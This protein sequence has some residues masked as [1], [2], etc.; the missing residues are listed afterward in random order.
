MSVKGTIIGFPRMGKQRELK[1]ILESY[2]KG[3]LDDLA[4]MKQSAALRKEHLALQVDAGLDELVVNDF[5]LYDHVLD[6]AMG[7][8]AIPERYLALQ[9]N[10]ARMYFAMARGEEG[11]NHN[12]KALEMSKWFNTN[13][14]YIVP[15][16]SAQTKFSGL[17]IA[18]KIEH[19]VQ[20]AREVI[21]E[22]QASCSVRPVLLGPISFLLLAK[23]S[24][25]SDVL[26]LLP[27]LFEEYCQVLQNVAEQGV[28]TIQIDEPF[29]VFELD[30]KTKEAYKKTY[31]GFAQRVPKLSIF[32]ASYFDDLARNILL[33]SQLPV[34]TVH[35]DLCYGSMESV[36]TL[37]KA[38]KNVSL[39]IING[40]N[41]WKADLRALLSTLRSF[42]ENNKESKDFYIS[43]SC[44]L[45]H[46]PFDLSTDQNLDAEIQNWLSFAVQKL[47]E[48]ALLKKAIVQG[49]D[50]VRN[51]L[52][53]NSQALEQRRNSAR[54]HKQEVKTRV[55][56]IDENMMKRSS[57]FDQRKKVQKESLGLPLFPSTTIGS[58]PQ[59]KEIRATRA[60]FKKGKISK[61]EYQRF[62]KAEIQKVVEFQ[63]EI[64]LDV[65]VH[66]EPERNDMVEYFG[67]NF[68][69]FI[70]T[71][72][73]WVQSYGSRCV[74][75]PIIYGDLTRNSQITVD[76]ICYA[77]SLTKKIMKGMLT[78]PVTILQWSF[79]R[80]DQS[81]A[82]TAYQIALLI[83]DE[84][85]DLETA[86]IRIIQV[87]EPA[88]R[89]GMPL[90]K[91]KH[92][93]YL[94]WAVQ[95]FRVSTSGVKDETQ[96][97]T[98]MC[99]SE[100]N[101]I[102]RSIAELDADVI[103][104]E[105]S[106]SNMELLEAF[107]DYQYPN[108]IGPGVYD[109]HSPRIPSV[110]EMVELLQSARSFI[111]DEQLWINPDCGLK[112][113]TWAEIR[114]SLINMVQAAQSIRKA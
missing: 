86:G 69:G 108:E 77:Q 14:H 75:P 54:V 45:L 52:E 48:V 35:V 15:E 18:K 34:Q 102:I 61:E 79:V 114:P 43:S 2:W 63:E 25:N 55:Q 82:D 26:S 1:K 51:E 53:T 8:S 21:K 103:S 58:Y 5:S 66:G 98:H 40:R 10:F 33:V 22:K 84:I 57:S 38:G 78:G 89:E 88:L 93:E 80:D 64:G 85:K 20:E 32:L 39:G 106:R 12:V 112:T 83:R 87:D 110:E 6:T 109:I 47:R 27:Q 3:E 113:R 42:V 71:S 7:F 59:T 9:D 4:L 99:Y 49:E 62:M 72:N 73:G 24:D 74:K 95:S 23:T 30:E 67:E 60:A 56:N 37:A 111:P 44:S 97:H 96:I 101:E 94:K 105:A 46:S 68:S 81:H 50:A 36:E 16:L 31:E 90:Q 28:E 13:Y 76:W 104:I 11:S 65:L 92:A 91:K 70:S 107:K 100:F 29:L 41:I 19:S 17:N